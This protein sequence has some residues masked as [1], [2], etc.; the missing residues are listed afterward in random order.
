MSIE[1]SLNEFAHTIRASVDHAG[2][3]ANNDGNLWKQPGGD[4]D[5]VEYPAPIDVL[6]PEGVDLKGE[7]LTLTAQD[8]HGQGD[9]SLTFWL[10]TDSQPDEEIPAI[11]GHY[12]DRH[13]NPARFHIGNELSDED[14]FSRYVTSYMSLVPDLPAYIAAHGMATAFRRGISYIAESGIAD[15]S[16]VK[17]TG[18]KVTANS[19]SMN[20]FQLKAHVTGE[21]D[22]EGN[23]TTTIGTDLSY[24]FQPSID[25]MPY[26]GY[27][28]K[29]LSLT[30][31]N[32]IIVAS[33]RKA[34]IS[35]ADTPFVDG[36]QIGA[37]SDGSGMDRDALPKRLSKHL[38]PDDM[39]SED[40][41]SYFL[42]L[43]T[44][45]LKKEDTT[46]L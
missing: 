30:I 36:D 15:D 10:K 24:F 21:T 28:L 11:I 34:S 9:D 42:H 44:N 27:L 23:T 2:Q 20:G 39:I 41:I 18:H 13:D 38:Y 17:R 3:E 12:H 29:A 8:W 43:V 40:D 6:L 16:I 32:D 22:K 33:E 14:T 5:Y 35:L 45:P 26:R 19:Y 37:Y 46:I 7:P 31:Q 1:N 25:E 4:L